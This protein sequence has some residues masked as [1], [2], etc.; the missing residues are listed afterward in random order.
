MPDEFQLNQ[1]TTRGVRAKQILE[2]DL[3][4]GAFQSLE[5]AYIAAWRE[6]AVD[7]MLGREK[8][9]LA[10]NIVGKVRQH[11]QQIMSDGKIA[12]S[13]LRELAKTPERKQRWQDIR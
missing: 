10:I 8:L 13:D 4:T 3:V 12:E 7:E 9:F 5:D 11:L 2:D 1:Q 6:T